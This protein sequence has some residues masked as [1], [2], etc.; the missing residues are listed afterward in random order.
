VVAA[1][2]LDGLG[3]VMRDLLHATADHQHP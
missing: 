3:G 2:G 1:D